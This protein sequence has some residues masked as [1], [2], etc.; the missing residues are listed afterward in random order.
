MKSV[1]G[2]LPE[3]AESRRLAAIGFLIRDT[4]EAQGLSQGQLG[5]RLRQAG[6]DLGPA[7]LSRIEYGRQ[8]LTTDQARAVERVLNLQDGRLDEVSA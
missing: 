5:T 3:T 6:I 8:A 4:R 2:Q 7:A 1:K